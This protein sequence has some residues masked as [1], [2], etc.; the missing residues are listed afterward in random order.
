MKRILVSAVALGALIIGLAGPAGA[1]VNLTNGMNLSNGIN[2]SNGAELGGLSLDGVIL[3][4]T[5]E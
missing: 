4:E 5:A 1:G 3:P 2:L